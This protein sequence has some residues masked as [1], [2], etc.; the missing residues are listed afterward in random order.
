MVDEDVAVVFAA[1]LDLLRYGRGEVLLS[2][3]ATS[4][5]EFR[6][7]NGVCRRCRGPRRGLGGGGAGACGHA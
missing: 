4:F 2:H 6:S 5:L 1:V 3:E 7:V